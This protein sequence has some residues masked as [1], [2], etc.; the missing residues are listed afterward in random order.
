MGEQLLKQKQKKVDEEWKAKKAEARRKK[1]VAVRQ[2]HLLDMRKKAEEQRKRV[3]EEAKKEREKKERQAKIDAGEVVADDEED[4]VVEVKK[5][6]DVKEEIKEEEDD[7]VKDEEMKEEEDVQDDD[8]P[9]PRVELTEEEKNQVFPKKEAAGPPDITPDEINRSFGKF[10]VPDKSEGFDERRYEW[11]GAKESYDYLRKWVVA[12]KQ[13]DRM[14]DLEPSAWWKDKHAE[15]IQTF[16][17]WQAKQKEFKN[18]EI[19]RAKEEK[20]REKE[21]AKQKAEEEGTVYEDDDE[22]IEVETMGVENLDDVG[23][24]EPL[25]GYFE[26]E[27]WALL[28]LRME[29][30]FLQYAFRKDV[31]DADRPGVHD[32]HL[33]FYYTKYF[34][35]TLNAKHFNA[36]THKEL[37]ALV[38]DTVKIDEETNLLLS[39][40]SDDTEQF[41]IFVKLTEDKRRA[42]QRRL[43]AGDETARIKYSP[44]ALQQ[45]PQAARPKSSDGSTPKATGAPV[46]VPYPT[47][48]AAAVPT[49]PTYGRPAAN[50]TASR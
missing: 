30:Y 50:T 33:A 2:K 7:E 29:L 34:R 19:M 41:D 25:Y 1:D 32:H 10:T 3:L 45:P 21:E 11:E 23:N 35:K 42:R 39:A 40:L 47:S 44:L 15:W 46:V 48:K 9:A 6:E 12:R 37:C 27:D 49:R 26:F 24:G 16:H 20:A 43:D 38:K 28:Q 13:N 22:E 5:E 18:S 4:D 14:D 31:D 36:S 17:D 8:E